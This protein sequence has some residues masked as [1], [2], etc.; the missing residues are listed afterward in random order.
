MATYNQSQM[1]LPSGDVVKF[2][3]N[4][5]GYAKTS[6]V[7]TA[8]TSVPNMDGTAAIG[9]AGQYATATHV[10]PSDT[11]KQDKLV[12]GT[13]IKTVEGTSLLGSGNIDITASMVGLGNVTNESKTTMFTNAALTGTPTAPTATSGTN[14]TQIATTAF[15]HSAIAGIPQS[16]TF[17]GTIGKASSGTGTVSSIPTSGVAVGDTWMI[18]DE[19]RTL[20]ASAS[21]TGNAVLLEV[22]DLIVATTTAPKWATSPSKEDVGVT[23]V[24][25]GTGLTGG[26]ITSSGTISLATSGVTSGTYGSSTSIPSITVD[27]YGRV[28]AASGN[29]ISIPSYSA[30][31]GLSL[32]SNTFSETYT[33]CTLPKFG[34]A[35]SQNVAISGVTANSHP[36]LDVY[37]DA[38]GNVSACNEAW[39]HIYKADSYN[40]GITF[41]SDAATSTALTIM[42]KGY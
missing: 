27:S 7:P 6:A 38:T 35:T 26:P 18:V 34:S 17:K 9:T 39:S 19:S 3:D 13:N 32:S 11:S 10:H 2:I 16:M 8:A 30:G 41:Y 22:G 40:G 37:I 1:T 29:S 25:T 12:S 24:A 14:T 33:T 5:S 20:S 21:A 31:A 42:V 28:T 15:V 36:V 23:S 4:T